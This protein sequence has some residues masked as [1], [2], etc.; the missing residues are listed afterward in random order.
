VFVER[1]NGD[2]LSYT[3]PSQSQ[4]TWVQNSILLIQ[5][6]KSGFIFDQDLGHD[7]NKNGCYDEYGHNKLILASHENNIEFINRMVFVEYSYAFDGFPLLSVGRYY[8]K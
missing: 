2:V 8:K 1:D 3:S 6:G 5:E 4:P 7:F